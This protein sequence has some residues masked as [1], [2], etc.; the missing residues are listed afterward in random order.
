[1]VVKYRAYVEDYGLVDVNVLDLSFQTIEFYYY[2]KVYLM[3]K[4]LI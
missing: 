2:K 4:Q 1:M 3:Q